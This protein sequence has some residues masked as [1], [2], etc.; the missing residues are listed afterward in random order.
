[1]SKVT[2]LVAVYNSEKYLQKCLA[3]LKEQ[4]LKDIQIVCINDCSSDNSREIIETYAQQDS[5]FELIN[6]TSNQGQAIARNTGLQIATGEYITML[7]SD[8]WYAPDTLEKAYNAVC[9][10]EDVDCAILRLKICKEKGGK[11]DIE[12]YPVRTDK[13]VF[14]GEEAFRL[15]LDWSLHG[16]YIIKAAIHKAYPYDTSCKLY[17]DDNTTRM[18]YLH[19][20]K[21]MLCQGEYFYRK[22]PDSMTNSKSILRFDTLEANL[23]MKRQILK[24]I[25]RGCISHPEKILK[26][27]ETHRWLNV[28]DT[29]WYFLQNRQS[30]SPEECISIKRRIAKILST[31]EQRLID[32]RLRRKFGYQPYK[33]FRIFSLMENCY[34]FLRSLKKS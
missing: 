18:H 8:D 21:V 28:V 6:Q 10:A 9:G 1:M 25:E 15:S 29:Y 33:S 7:D 2:V 13:S 19:S 5:R 23:S 14:T 26:L 4:T 22:H 30:F 16:L 20:R 3:S 31:I 24:E 27:Y 11:T 12:D 34:F 17:S 32:K